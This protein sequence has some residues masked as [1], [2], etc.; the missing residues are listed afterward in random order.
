M[1]VN[2]TAGTIMFL[3][4]ASMVV[5]LVILIYLVILASRFVCAFEFM[6]SSL[7]RIAHK[8][9]GQTHPQ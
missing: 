4:V 2:A 9:G 8:D 6:A 1:D 7:D 3:S 5:N